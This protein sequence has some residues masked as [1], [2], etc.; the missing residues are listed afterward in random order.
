MTKKLFPALLLVGSFTFAQVGFNTE[1]PNATLDV[2]GNPADNSKLDGII[3]PRISG[4]Q[5][6]SKTYTSSQTGAL[7]YVT[8]ADTSP[9]GQT[10]EVNASGYYFFNGDP[11]VNRWAKLISSEDKKIRTM[12][13]GMA[14]NEDYTLLL[15][16][17]IALPA[18]NSS[19]QGKIYNLINDTSGNIT[20][21]GT[22]RINGSNFSNYGLNTNDWG[23]GIVVQ[24]TGSAWAVISRY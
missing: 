14:T 18:A 13:T 1:L 11:A 12:N 4:D 7:V 20:I 10:Q 6:R 22:F 17:N 16:G 24:S 8:T 19:N 15:T 2:V 5:L 21:N 23:K 3:A 9:S